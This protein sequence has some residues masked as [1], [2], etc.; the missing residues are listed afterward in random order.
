MT[1][2]LHTLAVSVVAAGVLA[3]TPGVASAEPG[4]SGCSSGIGYRSAYTWAHCTGGAGYVRAI[5]TCSSGSATKKVNGPWV[6]V[7]GAGA[8]SEAH[9][10]S[11]YPKAVGHTYSTKKY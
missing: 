6:W 11:G 2:T 1:K 7:V 10:P 4:P 9:C 3:L 5:A 8:Q